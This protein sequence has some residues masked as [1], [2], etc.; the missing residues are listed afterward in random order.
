MKKLLIAALL[1]LLAA[2]GI[3]FYLFNKKV[4]G[5]ANATPDFHHTADE[6]YDAFDRD[7]AEANTMYTG[8]IID[9]SGLIL[10]VKNTN[11]TANVVLEAANA[12]AGGINCSFKSTVEGLEKGREVT[13]RGECQ[14]ILMDVVLNNCH[15]VKK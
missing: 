2:G 10:S 11:E 8:K 1:V 12:M 5:L 3:G 15:L 14:G 7:E 4:P 6:L 9:V 13:I